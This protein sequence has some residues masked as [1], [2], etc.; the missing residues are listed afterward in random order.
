[1]PNVTITIN[2]LD[3][4]SVLIN[5]L[6]STGPVELSENTSV[7]IGAI[8]ETDSLF[9]VWSGT[10]VGLLSNL[11]NEINSFI[12]PEND[13]SFVANFLQDDAQA[14]SE[15]QIY[16]QKNVI[17][18]DND[19]VLER[20]GDLLIDGAVVVPLGY[21]FGQTPYSYIENE[22]V[23][24][25]VALNQGYELREWYSDHGDYIFH[26]S[27]QVAANSFDM[28][29]PN[30]GT[31]TIRANIKALGPFT[32]TVSSNNSLAGSVSGGGQFD[33]ISVE[34]FEAALVNLIVNQNYGYEFVEWVGD[35]EFIADG[36]TVNDSE[37][38]VNVMTN[39]NLE[40]IFQ[41]TEELE[42][43]VNE[44]SVGP[45]TDVGIIE[46][47]TFTATIYKHTVS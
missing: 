24:I 41:E 9:D 14:V 13:V 19:I 44:Q 16:F 7:I 8:P 29:I 35:V 33:L 11:N 36:Y 22:P 18:V 25:N 38:E 2:P 42:V 12:M 30:S 4:G 23:S 45:Y 46:A 28:P 40:A 3:A 43:F 15:Y 34:P 31:L 47:D 17:Y 5:N 10:D 26:E 1:M 6:P 39:I 20:A 37:I 27:V 32:L 21:N